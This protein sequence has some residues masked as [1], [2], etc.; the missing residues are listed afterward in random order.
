MNRRSRMMYLYGGGYSSDNDM[1]NRDEYETE[2][3]FRDRRGREHYDNG[4][5][6]P[7]RNEYTGGYEDDYTGGYENRTRGMNTI[8]FTA[9]GYRNE[10][11][12]GG[13]S[14]GDEYMRGYGSTEPMF[15]EQMAKEW[16]REMQ[17]ADGTPPE[18]WDMQKVKQ[19]IKQ[20]NL[21]YDPVE[22]YIALNATYSDLAP[23]FKKY[24]INNDAA[25]LDFTKMFWLEDDDAVDNKLK[26][27]YMHVVK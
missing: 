3:R 6:A 16:V 2:S 22:L 1:R 25:Y 27:Y 13:G 21:D 24:G 4:R 12:M 26:A 18:H 19:L 10:M 5:Y 8:G 17:N 23:F 9:R 20:K 15:D 11:R 7:M 14:R